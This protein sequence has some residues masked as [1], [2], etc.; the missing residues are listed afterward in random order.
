MVPELTALSP[1]PPQ[2]VVLQGFY[3]QMVEAFPH[4]FALN[5]QLYGENRDKRPVDT[6]EPLALVASRPVLLGTGS[7]DHRSDSKAS[8]WRR[9]LPNQSSVCWGRT[10]LAPTRYPH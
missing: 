3:P 6:H 5:Y 4:Q 2:S 10:G 8:S 9:K 1:I 7:E